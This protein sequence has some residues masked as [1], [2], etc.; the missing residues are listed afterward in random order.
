MT[1]SLSLKDQST[2]LKDYTGQFELS[3]PGK[4][5]SVSQTLKEIKQSEFQSMLNARVGKMQNKIETTWTK[6]S[7][8]ELTLSA[9]FDLHNIEPMAFQGDY[10]LAPKMLKASGSFEKGSNKYSISST[11]K[12]SSENTLE[13]TADIQY[14]SRRIIANFEQK[15]ENDLYTNMADLRWDA[16][17][18]D[19][20][21]VVVKS[22]GKILGLNNIEGSFTIQYPS[23]NIAFN[24]KHFLGK[25]YVSHI[26]MQWVP[27]EKYAI[28]TVFGQYAKKG[29]NETEGQIKISTPFKALKDF[30][31]T[32]NQQIQNSELKTKLD[33]EWNPKNIISSTVTIRRPISLTSFDAEVIAKTPFASLKHVQASLRHRINKGLSTVGKASWNKQSAQMDLSFDD[34]SDSTKTNMKG[35][36]NIKTSFKAFKVAKL[37]AAYLNDGRK[38]QTSMTVLRNKKEYGVSTSM[39]HI[40]N[41]W[42]VNNNGELKLYS[43]SEEVKATWDHINTLNDITTS[44]DIT[45]GKNKRLYVKYNGLQN[46]RKNTGSLSSALEIKSSFTYLNDLVAQVSHEHRPGQIDTIVTV[47]ND[48]SKVASAEGKYLRKNGQVKASF[49]VS[50]PLA[51]GDMTAELTTS[52]ESMPKSIHMEVRLTPQKMVTV[53]G[54][55]SQD[56]RTNVNSQLSITSP[57]FDDIKIEGTRQVTPKGVASVASI[58]YVPGKVLRIQSLHDTRNDKFVKLTFQSPYTRDYSAEVG[59]KGTIQN[60]QARIEAMPFLKKWT[61]TGSYDR[62]GLNLKVNTPYPEVAYSQV[63]IRSEKTNGDRTSSITI[64]YMPGQIIKCLSAYNFDDAR[65]L[66]FSFGLETPF[67]QFPKSMLEFTHRGTV[68]RFANHI[69]VEYKPGQTVSADTKFSSINGIEGLV[70][71]ATPWTS[72]AKTSLKLSG[73]PDDFTAHGEF[74][75]KQTLSFDVRHKGSLSAFSTA[76]ELENGKDV[77]SGTID[78]TNGAKTTTDISIRTPLKYWKSIKLA[79]SLE[80]SLAQFNNHLELSATKY[81]TY[82]TDMRLDVTAGVVGEISVQTPIKE[83]RNMKVSVSHAGTFERFDTHVEVQNGVKKFSGD[84][85]LATKPAINFVV[86]VKTPIDGYQLVQIAWTHD[87]SATDFK[88]NLELQLNKDISEIDLSYNYIRKL[89]IDLAIRSPYFD[90]VKISVDH[91]GK[92]SKFTSKIRARSGKQRMSTDIQFQL[93]PSLN[94]QISIKSPFALLKN[95][96]LSIKHAGSLDSFKCNMLYRCNGKV[97]MGDATF[98][99]LD[100]M[101]GELNLKG[102]IFKPINVAFDLRNSARYVKSTA[103][104]SLGKKLVKIDASLDTQ[105]GVTGNVKFTSPF[106]GLEAVS[107][108][109]SHSGELSKFQ[110]K[111]ELAVN[112]RRGSVVVS[113]DKSKDITASLEIVTPL[114]NYKSIS[115]S[116]KHI[117]TMNNFETIGQFKINGKALDL[118]AAVG[119][120]RASTL[121]ASLISKF[122]SIPN[123]DA[124]LSLNDMFNTRGELNIG[125]QK[126]DFESAFNAIRAGYTGKISTKLPW[127]ERATAEF[128]HQITDDSIV[129]EGEATY[130]GVSQFRLMSDIQKSPISL[131]V[132]INTPIEKF[133]NTVFTLLYSNTQ[134]RLATEASLMFNKKAHEARMSMMTSPNVD[135]RLSVRSPLIKDIDVTMTVDG[136]STNFRSQLESKLDRESI[137]R[138]ELDLKVEG[139]FSGDLKIISPYAKNIKASFNHDGSLKNFKSDA[140]L[141][142]A[143]KK[144]EFLLSLNMIGEAKLNMKLFTPLTKDVDVTMTSSGNLPH[145]S[146]SGDFMYG[147]K[148][149]FSIN[150]NLD[151]EGSVN[152]QI[153][154]RTPFSG[155]S[156]MSASLAHHGKLSN[157]KTDAEVA[158]EGKTSSVEISFNPSSGNLLLKSPLMEDVQ[159]SFDKNGIFPSIQSQANVLYGRRNL[160]DLS[161]KMMLPQEGEIRINSP[162]FNDQPF[163]AAFSTANKVNSIDIH[164]EINLIGEKHETDISIDKEG[165]YSASINT[166]KFD[167]VTVTISFVKRPL[168]LET[169]GSLEF[170]SS[171][172]EYDILVNVQDGIEGTLHLKSTIVPEV[173][174]TFST[175]SDVLNINAKAELTYDNQNIFEVNVVTESDERLSGSLNVK[176]MENRARL[177][178]SADGDYRRFAGHVAAALNKHNA[179]VDVSLTNLRN[180]QAKLDMKS[181]FARPVS[182][183]Y[184][185]ENDSGVYKYQGNVMINSDKHEYDVEINTRRQLSTKLAITSPAIK[186]IRSSFSLKGNVK[187]FTIDSK[188]AYGSSKASAKIVLNVA[189]AFEGNVDVM[190]PYTL[191][192]KITFDHSGSVSNFKTV[193]MSTYG[194]D[195]L[196]NTEITWSKTPLHGTMQLQTMIAGYENIQASFR[197]NG[198]MLSFTSHAEVN[199]SGEKSELDVSLN[200]KSKMEG[201]LHLETPFTAPLKIS[202]EHNGI[203]SNFKTVAGCTY[204]RDMLFDTEITWSK[205][206]LQGKLQLK[207]MIPGYENTQVSFRHDVDLPNIASQTQVDVNGEKA[208]FDLSI[209]ANK[210]FEGRIS[211]LTPYTAPL[212]VIFDHSGSISD[213]KTLAKSTYGQRTMFDTEITWTERPMQGKLRVK[214]DISGYE[215]IQASFSHNGEMLSFTNHAEIDIS[216]EKSELDVSLNAATKLEGRMSARSPY[217]PSVETGFELTGTLNKFEASADFALDGTKYALSTSLDTMRDVLASFKVTTP[218][219][220]YRTMTGTVSHT[221]VF[222]DIACSIELKSGRR[223]LALGRLETSAIGGYSAKMSIQSAITPTIQLNLGQKGVSSNFQSVADIKY[224]GK[225]TSLKVDHKLSS[226]RTLIPNIDSSYAFSSPW[227]TSSGNFNLN[228]KSNTID[229]KSDI[230]LD[231]NVI[232]VDASLNKG[233]NGFAAQ[234]EIELPSSERID[235]KAQLRGLTG[236]V[237]LKTPYDGFR[238]SAIET[239]YDGQFPNIVSGMTLTFQNKKYAIDAELN[240]LSGKLIVSTPFTGYEHT[241]VT[242]SQQGPLTNMQASLRLTVMNEE[243]FASLENKLTTN[244]LE[245]KARLETPYT[246]D[247]IFELTHTGSVY[248]FYNSA[249]LSMGSSNTVSSTTNFKLEQASMEAESTLSTTFSGYSD[250]HKIKIDFEQSF[251]DFKTSAFVKILGSEYTLESNLDT[252]TKLTGKLSLTTPFQRFRDISADFEHTGSARRFT[253]KAM[254]GLNSNKVSGELSYMKYGWRRLQTTL[255]VKTTF[256]GYEHNKISYRHT[257]SVDSF[258]CNAEA[259]LLNEDFTGNLRASKDPM[260]AQ[261]TLTTPF[262]AF[263]QVGADVKIDIAEGIFNTEAN[264][265]YMQDKTITMTSEINVR[266][267]PMQ[268]TLKFLTPFAGY[269]TTDIRLTHS[270]NLRNFQSI[271]S[272]TTPFTSGLRA[273]ANL[274]SSSLASFDAGVVFN[275]QIKN[276][277]NI[278]LNL[279]NEGSR[280]KYTSDL[281]MTWAPSKSIMLTSELKDYRNSMSADISLSTPFS[282]VRQFNI[283][284]ESKVNG[285]QYTESVIIE[286]NQ[287]TCIDMDVNVDL[288]A[289]SPSGVLNLREPT[290]LRAEV[291]GTI[292]RTQ[293]TGRIL[294]NDDLKMHASH[295]ISSKDTVFKYECPENSV[296]LKN[297][298]HPSAPK[299]DLYINNKH[300]GYDMSMA[301][302]DG[303]LKVILPTRS[304]KVSGSNDQ[305]KLEGKF[306]WDADKD[307]SKMVGIKSEL[308]RS[309]DSMKADITLQMPSLGKVIVSN[310]ELIY[311]LTA[312]VTSIYHTK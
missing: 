38:L 7:P 178:G 105:T 265:D 6:V 218:I 114:S 97:F 92:P 11:S 203:I 8:S 68:E 195:T 278:K 121:S 233:Q 90:A 208:E 295:D 25:K 249:L 231:S 242:F 232:S 13:T 196:L 280:G 78:F 160:F 285:N 206:P 51:G 162:L 145:A 241:A 137:L 103:Q 189:T 41:G 159:L 194:R 39:K 154:I 305:G 179:E 82:T 304:L 72:T 4:T 52:Y 292:D 61:A 108:S 288:S 240:R 165:K 157:F 198:D 161:L 275:S 17:R 247:L 226:A 220:G 95:Q 301:S 9:K 257:A 34:A 293:Y 311:S 62:T 158:L 204:G 86:S 146:I 89:N 12:M 299:A 76:V 191:P 176:V 130:G 290:S 112:K 83:Y 259:S 255:D 200:A 166:P 120:E 184:S 100:T 186:P 88:S 243:I 44:A 5:V 277:E 20:Q 151:L 42:N 77:V 221:G 197:H 148:S 238:F 174:L 10:K 66:K 79:H 91:W 273:Q 94:A 312:K 48:G 281:E 248:D 229:M 173:L 33:V 170:G 71:I 246:E 84:V 111:G 225:T 85:K 16:D 118:R 306:M 64:E 199:L 139:P 140:M 224:N 144:T 227:K 250:E 152:S 136:K 171:R 29:M 15:K 297:K 214:T 202:F 266:D 70:V 215:N 107:A 180:I 291:G 67:N 302:S 35:E 36:V 32:I 193:A 256:R 124:T 177:E 109:I 284:T 102:P 1:A 223:N 131:T 26:D 310:Q 129:T 258:E 283:K 235:L 251:P 272:I 267:S 116:I 270:G 182:A 81:G 87:G 19:S 24:V 287:E 244:A 101:K 294:I 282:P 21:R 181:S 192:L 126:F 43:P 183:I 269:E 134:N 150:G 303:S 106:N 133:E 122:S 135:A 156:Q 236:F 163:S 309:A 115:A 276:L 213:F 99:K 125:Q 169:R 45:W 253:T 123:M 57:L 56:S 298:M 211:L 260:K 155:L 110:T 167:P 3:I 63:S 80:G 59:V 46:F 263:K 307:E 308:T 138:V 73:K 117:G 132:T 55:F 168:A 30:T 47:I 147:G 60:F 300:Y 49:A 264:I 31:V 23:R 22:K 289:R 239:K 37:N 188:L 50:N 262:H 261:I 185:Y 28:D 274:R 175:N 53:D 74:A 234:A 119:N 113:F 18:D 216:G 219:S 58:E 127:I 142:Y 149:K 271:A 143:G 153:N 14:P 69:L 54:T 98:D 279:K 2:T 190:T 296:L 212:K 104:A 217:F 286:H 164:A 209:N 222:P 237:T 27:N 205:N 201:N 228:T 230:R 187:D 128:K 172:H 252:K 40:I 268:V 75:W 210:N 93:N 207:S 141:V 254:T 245:T 96:Q 65:N